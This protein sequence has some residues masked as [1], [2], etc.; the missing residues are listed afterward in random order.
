MEQNESLTEAQLVAAVLES[1]AA[2]A[3]IEDQWKEL[4]AQSRA[5]C[6]QLIKAH[7]YSIN[8]TA[9]L[10]GH[11]RPTITTWLAADGVQVKG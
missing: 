6:L 7:G 9:V 10:S 2:L 5:Q 4:R 1:R 8:K 11:M 3:V